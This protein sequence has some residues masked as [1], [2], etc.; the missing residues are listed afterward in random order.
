[1]STPTA[2][3]SLALD[4]WAAL[5]AHAVGDLTNEHHRYILLRRFG[6]LDGP[7]TLQ[8]IADEFAISREWV[9]QLEGKALTR[10]HARARRP[11]TTAHALAAAF[12]Q[13]PAHDDHALVSRLVETT[14]TQFRC[15]PAWLV[16]TLSRMA[17]QSPERTDHLVDLTLQYLT[18]RRQRIRARLHAQQRQTAIDQRLEKWVRDAAWPSPRNTATP[19]AVYRHRLPR[20]NNRVGHSGSFRSEK[21]GRTVHFESLL[22]EAALVTAEKSSRVRSYQEQPCAIPYSSTDPYP[23]TDSDPAIYVPDLLITLDDGRNLLI[24]IKPLWQMAVTDNRIKTQAGQSFAHNQG[25]GW[26]TVAHAGHTY[27]DLLHRPINPAAHQALA[28]ALTAGPIDWPRMQQ[29]RQRTPIAALDVAAYAAQNNI[30]LSLTP[31]RLGP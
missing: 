12:D 1:M 26:V 22:E 11:G 31:Y 9:R 17:G 4:D 16:K 2:P 13:L 7:N 10:I 29:L 28:N 27:H 6:L 20:A 24:E 18:Y 8:A 19:V 30:A 23:G 21:L 3:A 25:W 14:G 15:Q 5:V